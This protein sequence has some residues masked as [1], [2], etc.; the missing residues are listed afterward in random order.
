MYVIIYLIN[1][2]LFFSLSLAHALLIEKRNTNLQGFCYM[3]ALF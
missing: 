1:K 3:S 2:W